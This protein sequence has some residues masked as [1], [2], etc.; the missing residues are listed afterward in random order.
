M[1]R[2]IKVIPFI[3]YFGFEWSDLCADRKNAGDEIPIPITPFECETGR[4][5][6]VFELEAKI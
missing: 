4:C 6:M 1:G 5:Q 3:L 2:Q